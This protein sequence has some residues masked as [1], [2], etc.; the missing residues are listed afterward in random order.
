MD[1]TRDK[2]CAERIRVRR[3][4]LEKGHGRSEMEGSSV[5][6]CANLR[7][8]YKWGSLFADNFGS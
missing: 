1:L 2:A 7:D 3:A 8:E 4:F 5:K 6:Q